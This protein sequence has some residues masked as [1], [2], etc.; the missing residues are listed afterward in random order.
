MTGG[1]S[2]TRPP[3]SLVTWEQVSECWREREEMREG[4]RR[5]EGGW[6]GM[7]GM[8]VPTCNTLCIAYPGSPP[9]TSNN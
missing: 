8:H 6:E 9:H 2:G 4:G 1:I 3:P 7:S 5:G